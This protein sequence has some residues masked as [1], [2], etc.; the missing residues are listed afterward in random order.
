M[1]LSTFFFC[2]FGFSVSE[3]CF[4]FIT[5]FLSDLINLHLVYFTVARAVCTLIAD[6]SLNTL[7][8]VSLASLAS[9]GLLNSTRTPLASLLVPALG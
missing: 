3:K 7:P 9:L 6:L 4:T 5:L 8:N 2:L 1:V